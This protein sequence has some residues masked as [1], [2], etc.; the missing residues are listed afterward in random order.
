LED[1]EG[2]KERVGK[3]QVFEEIKRANK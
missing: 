1:E 2:W 3:A